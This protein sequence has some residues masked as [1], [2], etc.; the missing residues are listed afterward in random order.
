ML[1]YYIEELG[2]SS[3]KPTGM[4]WIYITAKPKQKKAPTPIYLYSLSQG[5]FDSGWKAGFVVLRGSVSHMEEP[6]S[7]EK[8]AHFSAASLYIQIKTTLQ[9]SGPY[10]KTKGTHPLLEVI[11]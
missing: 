5:E 7:F 6:M 8:E 11:T 9:E 10:H 3:Q 1:K 4:L 2:F